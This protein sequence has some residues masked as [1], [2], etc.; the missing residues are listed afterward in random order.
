MTED[1]RSAADFEA[2]D[3]VAEITDTSIQ[4]NPDRPANALTL[5]QLRDSASPN[6][7][8][9]LKADQFEGGG[10]MFSRLVKLQSFYY[11]TSKPEPYLDEWT[12]RPDKPGIRADG[13]LIHQPYSQN[14][15]AKWVFAFRANGTPPAPF[16]H[17][18]RLASLRDGRVEY[19]PNGPAGD[20][21]FPTDI[22][23]RRGD[24]ELDV[25]EVVSKVLAIGSRRAWQQL[26]GIR[27]LARY[28]AMTPVP[29]PEERAY[30]KWDGAATFGVQSTTRVDA[31]WCAVPA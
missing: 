15:E 14:N 3:Q 18:C 10:W 27:S 5:Q 20:T 16:T 22:F 12:S 17:S 29:P 31:L 19:T 13:G 28:G 9:G 26:G 24:P 6:L 30:I 4:A 21:I 2:P 8:A 25:V 1:V 11:Y 23:G 7:P